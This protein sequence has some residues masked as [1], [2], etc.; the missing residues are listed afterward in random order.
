MTDNQKIQ[1]ENDD[2]FDMFDDLVEDDEDIQEE[3]QSNAEDAISK[4]KT[5]ALEPL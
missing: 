2:A 1:E 5:N 3:T 4:P